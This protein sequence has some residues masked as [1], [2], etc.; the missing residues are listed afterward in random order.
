M[1]TSRKCSAHPPKCAQCAHTHA[2]V[3]TL[4]HTY[5]KS[6]GL[7]NQNREHTYGWPHISSSDPHRN[8][9]PSLREVFSCVYLRKS[10]LMTSLPKQSWTDS[11]FHFKM[12]PNYPHCRGSIVWIIQTINNLKMIHPWFYNALPFWN[13]TKVLIIFGFSKH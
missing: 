4:I 8:S 12:T 3:H 10:I 2:H 6:S 11:S 7:Q 1:Q 9:I 5:S 13:Q